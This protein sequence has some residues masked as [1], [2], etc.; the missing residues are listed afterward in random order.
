MNQNKYDLIANCF[1][2]SPRFQPGHF[3]DGIFAFEAW[4]K[5]HKII[6]NLGISTYENNETRLLEKSSKYQNVININ[7]EGSALIWS[8]F[9]LANR[10]RVEIDNKYLSDEEYEITFRNNGF[11]HKKVPFHF[12][13][14]KFKEDS[15]FIEDKFKS[16]RNLNLEH[17]IFLESNVEFDSENS[18]IIFEG[19]PIIKIISKSP[20]YHERLG[21]PFEFGKYINRSLI[22][23]QNSNRNILSFELK[24]I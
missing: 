13:K 22:K 23:V 4:F 5:G 12:K 6:T 20:I 2:P 19:K 15:V 18:S 10:P 8:S 24:I 3:H 11:K 17:R 7:G 16:K 9:R 21:T 14:F 1:G